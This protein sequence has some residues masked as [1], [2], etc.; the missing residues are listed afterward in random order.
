MGNPHGYAEPNRYQMVILLAL[1]ELGKHIY[2]GTVPAKEVARRRV[3]N[4]MARKSR[5]A[6]RVKS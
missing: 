6:N 1:N 5:R 2:A 3:K 4:K